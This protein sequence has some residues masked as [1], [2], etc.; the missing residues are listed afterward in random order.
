MAK[1]KDE[2]YKRKER[3]RERRRDAKIKEKEEENN[4]RWQEDTEDNRKILQ[5]FVFEI[6]I[7][8]ALD[9]ILYSCLL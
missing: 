4:K 9:M 5:Y 7:K 6:V 8:N 2:Q 1:A 3:E